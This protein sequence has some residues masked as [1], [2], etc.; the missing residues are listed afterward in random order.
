MVVVVVVVV[1]VALVALVPPSS[2]FHL[3]ASF[4]VASSTPPARPAR[5]SSRLLS[6]ALAWMPPDWDA[7]VEAVREATRLRMHLPRT[8]EWYHQ[9]PTRSTLART[10]GVVPLA[11]P[12]ALAL[13][14]VPLLPLVPLVPLALAARAPP[15]VPL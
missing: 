10:S 5:H 11:V 2:L 15:L 9:T 4:F 8:R 7:A 1:V 14:L 3:R 12:L 6:P 13:A